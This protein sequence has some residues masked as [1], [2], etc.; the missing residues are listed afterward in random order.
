[1]ELILRELLSTRGSLDWSLEYIYS[2]HEQRCTVLVPEIYI[3]YMIISY[4]LHIDMVS[5]WPV[6]L[7]FHT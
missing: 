3:Y 5:Y 1:M 2:L 4:M 7:S 6:R